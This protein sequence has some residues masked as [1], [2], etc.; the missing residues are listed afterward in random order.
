LS[1]VVRPKYQL[2]YDS[3][4]DE[5]T[6]EPDTKLTAACGGSLNEGEIC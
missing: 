5:E 2:G 1:T 6:F 3:I 4:P